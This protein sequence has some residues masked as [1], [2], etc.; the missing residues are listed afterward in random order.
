[1]E[2]GFTV[3]ENFSRGRIVFIKKKLK[4]LYLLNLLIIVFEDPNNFQ[5]FLD[6]A[7]N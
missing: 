6:K 4:V 5:N 2:V 3:M 7:F 1:M